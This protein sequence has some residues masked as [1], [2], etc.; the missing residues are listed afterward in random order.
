MWDDLEKQLHKYF[1]AEVQEMKL[2]DLI[3]LK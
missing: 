2:T 3:A 1:F